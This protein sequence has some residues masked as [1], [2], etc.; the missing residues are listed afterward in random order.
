MLWRGVEEACVRA[1]RGSCGLAALAGA[2]AECSGGVLCFHR[3]GPR[4]WG[5]CGLG[6]AGCSGAGGVLWQDALAGLWR[7]ALAGALAGCS[8]GMLWRGALAGYSSGEASK[9]PARGQEASKRPARSQQEA[10]KRPARPA[11]SQQEASKRPARGQQEASKRPARGRVN[12]VAVVL[13]AR[14]VAL[15]ND[16]HNHAKC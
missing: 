3:R 6:V 16:T 4:G 12:L 8:G 7:G 2:L 13:L 15:L 1:W 9:M 14:C 10:S 5:S 11:R